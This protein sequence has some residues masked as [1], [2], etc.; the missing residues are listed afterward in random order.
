MLL[1]NASRRRADLGQREFWR[2]VGIK[3]PVGFLI[4]VSELR[5]AKTRQ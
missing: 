4:G 5:V 3:Q 1:M 2:S